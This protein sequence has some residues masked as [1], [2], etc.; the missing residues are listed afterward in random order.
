MNSAQASALRN[1]F[2]TQRIAALGTLREGGPWVSMVPFALLRRPDRFVIHVSRLAAHTGNMLE[3]D[4]VSLLVVAPETAAT[5]PQALARITIQGLA[6]RVTPS[7]PGY[8]A[9]R[10]AYLTRFPQT[11]Q[12]LEL[13]D[14]SFFTIRPL[15]MRFIA[16]FA[17][18]FTLTPEQLA[19][20][21]AP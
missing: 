15:S 13:H 19:N 21:L 16:G 7:A 5:S 8:A 18:A 4:R 9:A 10:E 3:S 17:Q 12:D 1:L 11:A 6:E 20:A 14:F 2:D